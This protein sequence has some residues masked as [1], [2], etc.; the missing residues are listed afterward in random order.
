MG[1][2]SDL[3]IYEDEIEID[4]K[5]TGKQIFI[6]TDFALERSGENVDVILVEE[7]ENHLSPVNLR[8][9]IQRVSETQSGQL[10]ITTHNSLISYPVRVEEPINHAYQ[11]DRKTDYA[12]GSM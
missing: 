7:P 6:K 10:F 2:E 3:M 5:G 4:S 11:R 12:E 9:L 1:L 8:K